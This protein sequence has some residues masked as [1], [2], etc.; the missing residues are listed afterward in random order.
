MDL[1]RL[2]RNALAIQAVPAPTFGEAAR[3]GLVH[4]HWASAG[5]SELQF[6]TAGNVLGKI[7][8]QAQGLPVVVSAHLD[9]VFSADQVTPATRIESQL[10]GPGIGDNAIALA[11]LIEL[12]FNLQET[13]PTSDVWLAANVCEEG[14]GNLLGMQ[15]VVE[16][17]G[18]RVAAYIVL[19][20]MALGHVYH[21]GLPI[22][23]FRVQVDTAGGHS[24]I[25]AG[26]AS[27]VHVLIEIGQ[28]LVRLELP[29]QPRTSLNIG[30]IL[31]GT[32]VNSV[33]ALAAMEIDLRSEDE[34]IVDQ[35]AEQVAQVVLARKTGEVE[36]HVEPIGHR[37]GGGLAPN[38]PLIENAYQACREAISAEPSLDIG[39]TDASLPLSLGLPAVCIGLTYGGGAH[40]AQEYVAIPPITA[41]YQ[42]LTRLI[43]K[44][45]EGG[46][47]PAGLRV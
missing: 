43:L 5:L 32:S 25:H 20:G 18:D 23:R 13:K 45:A 14:L 12:G 47:R 44:S 31:G 37:P 6:D 33:A 9:S 8:G 24:W 17:F 27:A 38:H 36:L 10:V 1:N 4:D 22:R 46:L 35:L 30:R 19:E 40:T 21:R 39:S 7:P 29:A 34:A 26:R 2:I 28:A 42:A 41:G 16:R 3:A 11:G 15:H